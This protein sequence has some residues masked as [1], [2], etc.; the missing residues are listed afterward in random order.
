MSSTSTRNG[1]ASSSAAPLK[2]RDVRDGDDKAV[3][4]LQAPTAKRQAEPASDIL[5][6]LSHLHGAELF[7]DP[8]SGD[9]LVAYQSRG[10]T[11]TDKI[12]GEPFKRWLRAL[13]YAEK[14]RSVGAEHVSQAVATLEALADVTGDEATVSVRVGGVADETIAV[15]LGDQTKR[16]VLVRPEEWSVSTSS[17]VRFFYPSGMRSLP[18]PATLGSAEERDRALVEFLSLLNLSFEGEVPTLRERSSR[19]ILATVVSYLRP[20]GPFPITAFIGE[21]GSAKTTNTRLLKQAIDPH[22]RPIRVLTRD[23]RDLA[24]AARRSRVLAFDNT[25]G[26]PAAISDALCCMSTGGAFSTRTLYTDDEETLLEVQRPVILNGIDDLGGRPD[27]LDRLII[28]ETPTIPRE[29]RCSERDVM[30]RFRE[31]HPRLLAA[32][33]DLLAGVMRLLP[34]VALDEMERMADFC[35]VGE[36]VGRYMFGPADEGGFMTIYAGD[37]KVKALAAVEGSLLGSAIMDLS[38]SAHHQ[39]PGPD[40]KPAFLWRGPM[41]SLLEELSVIVG[42][43]KARGRFWPSEPKTLG[44]K[45]R[46]LQTVLRQVGVFAVEGKRSSDTREFIITTVEDWA[47]DPPDEGASR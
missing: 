13:Y 38:R 47:V 20:V 8:G 10:A 42:P 21:Q 11:L 41:R 2:R 39:R 45:I 3:G 27:L 32:L 35:L 7:R 16:V 4:R 37:Q 40:G 44:S 23:V 43:E 15:A 9:L 14:N 25:S 1:S 33:L 24:V 5:V 12:R 19:L 34:T 30:A 29:E 26:V 36:S 22:Q 6:R 31:L 17:P 46:R 18:V 28:H